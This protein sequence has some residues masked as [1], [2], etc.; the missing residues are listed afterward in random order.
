[1]AGTE[2]A[3]MNIVRTDLQRSWL[4]GESHACNAGHPLGSCFQRTPMP[5][6]GLR[7]PLNYFPNPPQ[8]R[9]RRTEEAVPS[10]RARC[11]E[12]WCVGCVSN[13]TPDLITPGLS[14]WSW[15]CFL[16]PRTSHISRTQGL[17]DPRISLL[18]FPGQSAGRPPTPLLRGLRSTSQT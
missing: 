16:V 12:V 8:I 4:R 11:P 1:M 9:R 10:Q 17:Y 5:R 15:P 7:S 3:N 14:P 18:G 13:S 2:K 6:R